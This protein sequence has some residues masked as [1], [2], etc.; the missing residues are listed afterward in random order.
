MTFPNDLGPRTQP[1]WEAILRTLDQHDW[2][3]HGDLVDAATAA[4]D[5]APKSID[6]LIR[7]GYR[8]RHYTRRTQ[9]LRTIGKIE[10][11]VYRRARAPR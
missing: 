1:A 6:E 11:A 9:K 2:V 5:L 4:S 10:S 8:T 3:T 7:K